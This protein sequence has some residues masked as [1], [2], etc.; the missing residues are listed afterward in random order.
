MQELF[1]FTEP[2]LKNSGNKN[3]DQISFDLWGSHICVKSN[4]FD[5][6]F[7][8]NNKYYFYIPFEKRK[9]F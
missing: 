8:K 1:I 6:W 5:N 7:I 2:Y 9:L 3:N 4:S